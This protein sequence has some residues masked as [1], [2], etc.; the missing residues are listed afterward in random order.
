MQLLLTIP[1]LTFAAAVFCSFIIVGLFITEFFRILPSIGIIGLTLTAICY[2][3]LHRRREGST[4]DWRIYAALAVV[5]LIHVV[6]GITTSPANLG[7]YRRDVVLQSPFLL[8]PLAFW[9]LPALPKQYLTWLWQLFIGC[10][11][12]AALGATGNYLLHMA[13]INEMYLHSKIMPTEPDHIRLSLMVTLATATAVVL[14]AFQH[15]LPKLHRFLLVSAVIVLALFQHLLAVRSGLVTFYAV[16]A[17]M[18]GWLVIRTR[19]YRRAVA[20]A[21]VLVLLPALSYVSFP[22]FQNKFTNTQD[23]LSKVNNT[24]AAN[25]YS[26]VARVYSYK[27]AA[28][29]ITANPWFGVSKADMPVEMSKHYAQDYPSIRAES[30][31]QP[32]NQFIYSAVA[33]GL[34]GVLLFTLS[35][36]Y[37]LLWTWP[38]FAPLVVIQ[39]VIVSL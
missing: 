13:E 39:Y 29:L 27:V 14:L 35:F 2:G 7:E 12:I 24:A 5:F 36:Y 31:I 19:E 11:V 34:V 33:F 26:L 3:V 9:L 18:T 1:R 15:N 30:Y 32:H 20:F 6:A 16:G 22:T 23:D 37:P 4:H 38:R 10:V 8:L 28:K 17:L 21:A 25:D